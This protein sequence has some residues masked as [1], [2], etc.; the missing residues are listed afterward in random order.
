MK[1]LY[2][3]IFPKGRLNL[4]KLYDII[5][6]IEIEKDIYEEKTKYE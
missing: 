3:L 5:K 6:N 1:A 4:F 2:I